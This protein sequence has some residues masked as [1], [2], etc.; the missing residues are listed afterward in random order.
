MSKIGRNDRCV[1]GSGKKYKKCC[2]DS[3]QNEKIIKIQKINENR[4]VQFNDFESDFDDEEFTNDSNLPIDLIN[5]NRLNE[6]EFAAI[7]L[8]EKYPQ[9]SDGNERLGLVYEAK[10]EFKLAAEYLQKALDQ[11]L[12]TNN[13][14]L[15]AEA[16][17]WYNK[18]IAEMKQ[19]ENKNK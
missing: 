15:D 9:M 2:W 8:L 7:K 16:T 18:K 6:A 10:G 19:L 17:D 13:S 12:I 5:E 1:C 14:P 4:S 11:F 3:V